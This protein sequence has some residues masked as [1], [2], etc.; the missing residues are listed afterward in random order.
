MT[1]DPMRLAAVEQGGERHVEVLEPETLF[2]E[3]AEAFEASDYEASARKYGLVVKHFADSRWGDP[4]RY[5][6]GLSLER[7]ERHGE[8][9]PYYEAVADRRSGTKDAHDALFR[10]ATCHES[11]E[12]WEAAQAVLS[13]ILAPEIDDILPV[14][15]LEAHA[16]RGRA[17]QHLADLALAERDYKAALE[18]YREHLDKQALASDPHVS[19]AQFQIGEIY[20]ELFQSIRFR[21]PLDRM[22]R[23]LE[24][25]SNLF[26]KAQ[27][28]YLR[29]VRLHHP[30]WAVR[31]GYRLGALYERFYD[32][33]LAAEVPPDLERE[34]VEVY[35]QELRDKIR[36][37]IRRAI[38]VYERNLQ[39]GER[40]GR[41]GEWVRRTEA[42]LARL[43]EIV[44][45]DTSR[46]AL[47]EI[48]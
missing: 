24:D 14:D 22:A 18:L 17:R 19:M 31:G 16:R 43:K 44:R 9:V 47:A 11:L 5:N 26:L 46:D 6:A 39:L 32:D 23:D 40:M 36:P 15:R 29:T 41:R 35:Y 45:D 27:N 48:E 10:L 28:A 21:L 42:S 2:Q 37:L 33:M 1:L 12:E 7:L 8:A 34:A 13:R 3:A 25:K 30:D 38:D 4:A 20:R